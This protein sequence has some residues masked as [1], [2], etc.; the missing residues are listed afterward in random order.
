MYAIFDI[1]MVY[2]ATTCL[3]QLALRS[4]HNLIY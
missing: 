4:L 3:Y 1:G 2:K